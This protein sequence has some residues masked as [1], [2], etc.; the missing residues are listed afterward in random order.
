MKINPQQTSD[1]EQRALAELEASMDDNFSTIRRK[2][3]R[4]V[5]QFHPD[6]NTDDSKAAEEKCRRLVA[7]YNI[8]CKNRQQPKTHEELEIEQYIWGLYESFWPVSEE[9]KAAK[10]QS[11]NQ[12]YQAKLCMPK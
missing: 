10:L 3:R 12:H 4:L 6:H 11:L 9:Y 5:M 1:L 2:Y 7:A 8:L